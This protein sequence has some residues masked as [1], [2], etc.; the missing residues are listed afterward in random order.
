MPLTQD[1]NE[2][3]RRITKLEEQLNICGQII[4]ALGDIIGVNVESLLPP[5]TSPIAD[6]LAKQQHNIGQSLQSPGVY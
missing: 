3:E 1:I 6:Q 2:H 5:P 4:S